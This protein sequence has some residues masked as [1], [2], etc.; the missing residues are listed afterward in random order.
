MAFFSRK[1]WSYEIF[2]LGVGEPLSTLIL[3]PLTARC[4]LLFRLFLRLFMSDTEF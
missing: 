1:P 2:G 3:D 4:P